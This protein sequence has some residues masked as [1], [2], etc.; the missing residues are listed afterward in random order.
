MLSRSLLWYVA[1][2]SGLVAWGG[3]AASM[4]WGLL[5]TTKLLGRRVRPNWMLDLHRFLGALALIF[6]GIHVTGIIFDTYA[7]IGLVSAFVP[8]ADRHTTVPL[9]MGIVSLYLLAAV[10]LTSLARRR[11]SRKLWRRVHALSFPLFLFSTLHAITEG[12]DTRNELLLITGGLVIAGVLL[13]A[14]FRLED[15][16]DPPIAPA[17]L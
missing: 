5:M 9:A 13:M 11:L 7:K 15:V 2:S 1:R 8:L 10:E 17:R 4:V 12:T 14:V 3:L 16:V 6:T